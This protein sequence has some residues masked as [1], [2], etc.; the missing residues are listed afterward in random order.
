[1]VDGNNLLH[2]IWASVGDEPDAE[3]LPPPNRRQLVSVL[4]QWAVR[5]AEPVTVV[6][7]GPVP[8]GQVEEQIAGLGVTVCYAG[9]VSADDVIVE[10]VG[11]SSGAR[12]ITVVSDDRRIGRLVKRRRAKV[13]ASM[14][15]Y[16]QVLADLTNRSSGTGEPREKRRGLAP[17]QTDR[18]LEEFGYDPDRIEPPSHP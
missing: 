13:S 6:F 17:E 5:C 2:A 11:Q 7:D 3:P 10:M 9:G 1:M 12:H 18:W 15:F 4:G 14:A 8:P 16:A